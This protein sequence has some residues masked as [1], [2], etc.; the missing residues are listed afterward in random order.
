MNPGT[1]TASAMLLLLA[2]VGH[3][4]GQP[5][6]GPILDGGPLLMMVDTNRDGC[7]TKAEWLKAGAPLSAYETLKD[8]KGC[9]TLARMNGKPAPEGMDSDHDG[10][11]SLQ[12][13]IAFDRQL[14]AQMKGS[15]ASGA[16]PGAAPR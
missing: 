11:L 8:E 2:L 4:H 5:K 6:D 3:A 13:L 9:V 1:P 10:K 15:A 12:E 7:A 16:A 14:A